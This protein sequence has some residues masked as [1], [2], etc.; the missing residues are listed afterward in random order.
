M[1]SHHWQKFTSSYFLEVQGHKLPQYL[2]HKGNGAQ[3][4]EALSSGSNQVNK[5]FAFVHSKFLCMFQ[6]C[7]VLVYLVLFLKYC[8][9]F[10]QFPFRLVVL[11]WLHFCA[12]TIY[13][14]LHNKK[15]KNCDFACR[16]GKPLVLDM[17][18]VDMFHTVSDRFD[19]I[20]KGLMDQIMDKSIMQEEK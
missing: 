17:M 13:Y 10:Q 19:E 2:K 4:S 1:A 15:H 14:F 18:E 5:I 20:E 11:F 7:N 3:Q 9:L 12:V 16:F 8:I 6:Q